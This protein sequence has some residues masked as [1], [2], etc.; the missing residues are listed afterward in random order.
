[1]FGLIKRTGDCTNNSKQRKILYLSLV[2]S[3]LN[4]NSVIWRPFDQKSLSKFEAIQKRAVKWML[5]E[6]Y[7][8]YSEEDY[9]DRLNKLDLF[10]INSIY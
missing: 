8:K 7:Q 3:Q 6:G 9:L 5:F 4:Y 1:M 10:P 2:L